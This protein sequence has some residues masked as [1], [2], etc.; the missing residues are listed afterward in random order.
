MCAYAMTMMC[1]SMVYTA[2]SHIVCICTTEQIRPADFLGADSMDNDEEPHKGT[3]SWSTTGNSVAGSH[4]TDE[5][6]F[7]VPVPLLLHQ[8]PGVVL[9]D[10]LLH[11]VI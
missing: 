5:W 4:A 8:M 1:V 7:V 6:S 10:I 2:C 9:L 3:E 11:N